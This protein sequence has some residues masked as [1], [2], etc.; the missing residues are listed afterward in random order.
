MEMKSRTVYDPI[1]GEEREME[2][3]APK[4][5]RAAILNL[6]YPP[7]GFMQAEAA[8]ILA[9]EI[10]LSDAQREARTKNGSNFFLFSVVVPMFT[11]L[12]QAGKLV[13][14]RGKKTPYVLAET[15]ASIADQDIL[16]RPAMKTTSRTVYDPVTGERYQIE[17]P[18]PQEVREAILELARS[19]SG[20][21]VAETTR[22]LEERFE[23]SHEQREATTKGGSS[24]FSHKIVSRMFHS[25]L[26]NGKLV[27]PGGKHTPYL[28]PE[29]QAPMPNED[30]LPRSP[31]ETKPRTVYDPITGE[32]REMEFPVP[33][34]VRE[35]ILEIARSSS[36]ITIG[37]ISE[38]LK[39]R[40][41]LSDEQR[42]AQAKGGEK[43]LEFFYYNVVVP[44]FRYLVKNGKLEQPGGART[45]Y[46]F[47]GP[48]P[49]P[50][51]PPKPADPIEAIENVYQQARAELA[52]DLLKE[53]KEKSP[54]FFEELV[55][56]LLVKMGYGGSREDAETVGRSHDGGID[57]IINEDRLGLDK[58]YV[59]AKRWGENSVGE[60]DIARF[61]GALA[62][63]GATKGIFITTS[64]FT[65]EAKEYEPAGF[66]IILI[67][68]SQLA[69]YMIE[70]NVGVSTQ[71]TYEI[72][73]VD[74]DYFLEEPK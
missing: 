35:A 21:K 20:I 70:H 29:T 6:N 28:L 40:F 51:F 18:A 13:Q 69:Q 27:R 37:E 14:P 56:D 54:S 67:D 68:G 26:E 66:A 41:E 63:K 45:P 65:K 48:T 72:K 71:K 3:P 19:S 43:F 59:Q 73:R 60:P 10:G 64:K 8:P 47:V 58:I 57:G 34:E 44:E 22:K 50:P 9:E 62:G 61:A 25:L 32:P 55:I 49:P 74:T 23:L 52:A 46:R 30:V 4:E 33:Q 24:F 12:L 2:F 36:E 31:V 53:I 16:P 11:S 7:G 1:T 42:E 17:F 5:I 39:E 38:K 15:Q